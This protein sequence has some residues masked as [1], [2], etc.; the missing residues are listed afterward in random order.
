MKEYLVSNTVYVDINYGSDT[1]GIIN[2]P[3][4]PFKS[5]NNAMIAI[6]DQ[7]LSDENRW[8]IKISPGNYQE[9]VNIS[10]F[11]HLYGSGIS[12]TKIQSVF[13]NGTCEISELSICGRTCPLIATKLQTKTNQRV[14]F[15]NVNVLYKEKTNNSGASVIYC[16]GA[17]ENNM[18]TFDNC[19]ID[20]NMSKN[21]ERNIAQSVIYVDSIVTLKNTNVDFYANH[22]FIAYTFYVNGKLDIYGGSF[23]MLVDDCP[24]QKV[25]MFNS[26]GSISA[27][28]NSS[29]IIIGALS[30]KYEADVSYL[31]VSDDS[32]VNISLS[33]INLDGVDMK[34]CNLVD[35]Q[36]KNAK[37]SKI[38]ILNVVF[39]NTQI[40]K[41][42]GNVEINYNGT[43][44][45]GSIVSNGGLYDK[46]K[47]VDEN[48]VYFNDKLYKNDKVEA[49]YVRENDSTLLVNTDVYLYDPEFAKDYLLEKGKII[50]IFNVGMDSIKL[51]SENNCIYWYDGWKIEPNGSLSL[52]NDGHMWYVINISRPLL[53][54]KI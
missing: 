52:Q 21:N 32:Y 39:P 34:Y 19:F 6:Y 14:L 51:I 28:N 7:K 36:T 13:A 42:K 9:D 37:N 1:T 27:I 50:T 31:Y 25:C 41:I 30:G 24:K 45:N 12:L 54:I 8:V 15:S 18:V 22:K 46:I 29:K 20:V 11:V 16:S 4:Y 53:R 38:K 5:I 48:N 3:I 49:Y 44:C 43:S 35:N 40:P 47:H 33:T 17:A 2:S 26:A 23:N 10:P